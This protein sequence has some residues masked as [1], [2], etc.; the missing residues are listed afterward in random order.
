M[1]V[2]TRLILAEDAPI[3]QLLWPVTSPD[4]ALNFTL[5][6]IRT[7]RRAAG[8][9]TW[10]YENGRERHFDLGQHVAI[11]IWC[12][13]DTC[14]HELEAPSPKGQ[15]GDDSYYCEGCGRAWSLDVV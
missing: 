7:S 11:A 6:E 10:V 3:G 14:S 5:M 1:T 9:V 13:A 8:L 12:P 2:A 15:A 4:K